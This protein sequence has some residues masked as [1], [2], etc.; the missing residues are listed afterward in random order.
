[1]QSS[2]LKAN[3]NKLKDQN[4][5][6]E[7]VCEISLLLGMRQVSLENTLG[8]DFQNNSEYKFIDNL[9]IVYN[10]I[11]QEFVVFQKVKDDFIT[12]LFKNI[13]TQ[14]KE[15]DLAQQLFKLARQADRKL[16]SIEKNELF[17]IKEIEQFCKK[18]EKPLQILKDESIKL[19]NIT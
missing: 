2:I 17:F 4:F 15:K 19:N 18:M 13:L 1:M 10:N 14:I 16:K 8:N 9:A 7:V 6:W 11:I 12:P 5:I 3:E